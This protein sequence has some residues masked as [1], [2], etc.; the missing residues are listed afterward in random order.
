[1]PPIEQLTKEEKIIVLESMIA[2]L[3]LSNTEKEMLRY[4][5]DLIE[6]VE[7]DD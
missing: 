2:I 6:K 1:M 4:C 3:G 7:E 5:R